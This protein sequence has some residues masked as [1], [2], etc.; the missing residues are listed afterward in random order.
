M[1]LMPLPLF[2]KEPCTKPQP[3]QTSDIDKLSQ[4][5]SGWKRNAIN[6]ADLPTCKFLKPKQI[7]IYKTNVRII[8]NLFLNLTIKCYTFYH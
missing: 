1:Q 2:E 8:S 3:Y 4:T 7:T 5:S 6:P